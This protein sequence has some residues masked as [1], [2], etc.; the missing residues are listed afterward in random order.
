VNDKP[1]LLIAATFLGGF[2]TAKILGRVV[3]R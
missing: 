1:E 2:V 3:S